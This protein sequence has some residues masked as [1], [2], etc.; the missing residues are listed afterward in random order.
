MVF[1]HVG[2]SADALRMKI[3]EQL[4]IHL[5][6]QFWNLSD[7]VDDVSKDDIIMARGKLVKKIKKLIKNVVRMSEKNVLWPFF[8]DFEFFFFCPFS[9]DF[10][11]SNLVR[12]TPNSCGTIE[13]SLEITASDS[14]V[15]EFCAWYIGGENGLREQ[16]Q[17]LENE[18]CQVL[19]LL[20]RVLSDCK[21]NNLGLES[22]DNQICGFGSHKIIDFPKLVLS[23]GPDDVNGGEKLKN[24]CCEAFCRDESN[25]DLSWA[26]SNEVPDEGPL[27]LAKEFP[28]ARLQKM[29]INYGR[30]LPRGEDSSDAFAYVF[31]DFKKNFVSP[32]QLMSLQSVPTVTPN[33][34][35]PLTLSH[36]LEEFMTEEVH[37]KFEKKKKTLQATFVRFCFSN[38]CF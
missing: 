31:V 35:G 28:N 34:G 14:P 1:D 37:P 18:D 12:G 7:L 5:N 30:N 29:A 36:L 13:T 32:S 3:A 27:G 2:N 17:Q 16:S 19:V 10:Y 20:P 9:C 21:Y 26:D 4:T 6:D 24:L 15:I 23:P 33:R 22:L 11:F 25:F 38:F 8:D